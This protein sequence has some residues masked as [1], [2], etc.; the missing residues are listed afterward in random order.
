MIIVIAGTSINNNNKTELIEFLNRT[1]N[2][3]INDSNLKKIFFLTILINFN[4]I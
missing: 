4:I 3:Y 2:Y 1:N